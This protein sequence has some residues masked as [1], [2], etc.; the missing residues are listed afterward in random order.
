MFKRVCT[1]CNGDRVYYDALVNINDPS[2]VLTFS[3][4]WCHDCSAWTTFK[5]EGVNNKRSNDE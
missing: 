1:E 5:P 4:V 3:A 2:D